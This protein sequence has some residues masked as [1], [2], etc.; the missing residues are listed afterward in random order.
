MADKAREWTDKQLA[1]MERDIDKTYKQASKELT[2]KWNEYMERGEKK[3][4]SLQDAYSEAV[5]GGDKSLIAEAKSK[6][7]DAKKSFTLQNDHYKEMV[8][9]VTLDMAQVNQQALSY[10]NGQLPNVYAENHDQVKVDLNN[11]KVDYTLAD[12][13]TVKRMIKD[14]DIKLPKKKISV[15]KDVAWNT[16]KINSS[17]LQ[18]ILQGES[19][20][21]IAKRLLPI[22]DSN[23]TSAIRNARTLV[24]GAENRGRLDSYHELA[25][26][27]IVLKKVW[28]ATGD[29]RTRD[30]H[31][32]M[33]GQEVDL[34]ENFVDGDG[35]ELEYPADPSGEPATVYNC[36]CSM[37]THIVG[38]QNEDGSID[39]IN[40]EHESGLH[41][42]QI[43]EELSTRDLDRQIAPEV[44]EVQAV[45]EEIPFIP[46]TSIEEAELYAKENF[47]VQ[48]KWSG[49]GNVS[50]KG[51][52][53]DNANEI[54]KTFTNLFKQYDI[55][56]LRNIGM[57]NFRQKI[58][59]DAKDAPMA[60]RAMFNGEIYFNPNILKTEK[61]LMDY[62]KKGQEAFDYCVN[63][64]DKLS[65]K[66]LELVEKYKEAGRQT[67]SDSS[68][69]PISAMLTHEIGHHVDH[70][71]ILGNKEFAQ[72]TRDGIDEYGSKL[73][74]YAS[75]SRGEYVAES[76]CAYQTGLG[77][78]DPKLSE[79]FDGV[80][81]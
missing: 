65:G 17:V 55:P 24:T 74:G 29:D 75:F 2:Q 54:N 47:V 11:A 27:G 9:S 33:D 3:L 70:Q 48:S 53:L 7:E 32:V 41:Q 51:L 57:M 40:Y 6:L 1:Q 10:I 67:V 71:V 36:R 14:G 38:V 21:K 4:S 44:Q 28:I 37:R 62:M 43:D 64:I 19:M 58:W 60:Y 78:I 31:L 66:Q 34:D 80:K 56:Q 35:N 26:Q 42:R 22:M 13:G 20:D 25:E 59:K 77:E 5:K 81:K 16:K 61:S 79:I 72:I 46:A 45:Q 18:G 63:N 23:R 68:D 50:Y 15:P 12:K 39:Y 52:S 69:N 76:F 49:E 73:S 8:D 30:A